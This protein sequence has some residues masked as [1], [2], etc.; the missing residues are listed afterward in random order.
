MI[1]PCWCPNIKQFL[2]WKNLML[3]VV[4]WKFNSNGRIF[5]KFR[6]QNI[7]YL[8]KA[9]TSTAIKSNKQPLKRNAWPKKMRELN[10]S[11]SNVYFYCVV[12]CTMAVTVAIR[13]INVKTE[14]V[15][16]IPKASRHLWRWQHMHYES[17]D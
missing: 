13:Y 10:N 1:W 11:K 8:W 14:F 3:I 17:F 9:V 7:N 4:H 2:N 15:T 16:N 6:I 5:N 12:Q